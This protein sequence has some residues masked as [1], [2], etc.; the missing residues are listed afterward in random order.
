MSF[1]VKN[2]VQFLHPVR[3]GEDVRFP[4][5]ISYKMH[6]ETHAEREREREMTV[7]CRLSTPSPLCILT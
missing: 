3:V 2:R 6:R 1:L 5:E 4:E 7:L